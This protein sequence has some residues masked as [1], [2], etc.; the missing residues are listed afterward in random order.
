M[1]VS[2]YLQ[3]GWCA[4]FTSV[5]TSVAPVLTFARIGM[6][7]QKNPVEFNRCIILNVEI[8][9]DFFFRFWFFGFFFL[10]SAEDKKVNGPRL[11]Y[12]L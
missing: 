7:L 3:S 8:C 2:I 1:L 4:R 11:R 9:K 10:E 12:S 5:H 6:N